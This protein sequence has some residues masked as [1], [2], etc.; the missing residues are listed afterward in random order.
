VLVLG[1][2]TSNEE[3]KGNNLTF[4]ITNLSDEDYPDNP[5]IGFRSENYQND[6]FTTG[7]IDSTA[8]PFVWNFVFR[9]KSKDSITFENIDIS[10][11]LPTI[12]THVKQDDYLSFIA[13]VNQEWN[14]NQVQ[15]DNTQFNSTNPKIV[16]ID[17]ARNCLN[18]YLWEIIAYIKEDGKTT[19][20]AH[21]WFDFPHEQYIKLFEA[22]NGVPFA[23]YK[24]N[25][26]NWADPESKKVNLD[27]LRTLTKS[28][29]VDF[30]DNSDAMYPQQGA[31]KK[32]L[33]EII[34]PKTFNT[35]RDLQSDST[36]F[37]TFTPPGFYNR[38]DP[39]TTE[40]G[41]LYSLRSTEVNETKSKTSDRTFHEIKLTFKDRNNDR[42]T[43]LLI[44][45]LDFEEFP[46]LATSEANSGWKNSM[47][48]S[49]HT[50][51]EKYEEQL[52]NK[53]TDSPYYALLLDE[54]G[55]WLDSH[56]VGIDGPIFHFSDKNKESLNL[57]LLSFERHALVGHYEINIGN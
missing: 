4:P 28:M 46:T 47:G 39:R 48:I 5:D 42:E 29:K 54:N 12:P 16:R 43:T 35:M 22:K 11:F 9:S 15:F 52:K 25:L 18:T 31:R 51:Y 45:G 14:R 13:C 8:R 38:K 26:E 36:L 6:F 24:E 37:A 33:K 10:E 55:K 7:R 32:K 56:K 19:P 53:S 20:Y 41:R 23:K 3:P 40:L 44:G 1:S 17:I 21:G 34:Y 2:C 30:T 27:V 50:F 57:W 49:N